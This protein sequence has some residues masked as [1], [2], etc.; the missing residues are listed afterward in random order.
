MILR[1][2]LRLL[3]HRRMDGT[4]YALGSIT[5]QYLSDHRS[6]TEPGQSRSSL[7][8]S[9]AIKEFSVFVKQAARSDRLAKPYCRRS[10]PG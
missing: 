6:I 8:P 10:R 5:Q 9:A 3:E 4:R 1:S 2:L 7:Q